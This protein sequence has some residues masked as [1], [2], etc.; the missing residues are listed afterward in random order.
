MKLCKVSKHGQKIALSASSP[1]ADCFCMHG[2]VLMV[3]RL[4]I[5]SCKIDTSQEALG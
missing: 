3:I 5:E 1:S 4:T 2:G